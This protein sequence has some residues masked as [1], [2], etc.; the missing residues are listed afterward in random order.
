ML[1]KSLLSNRWSS[2]RAQFGW[3]RD[4]CQNMLLFC[5]LGFF[6]R[7]FT[8]SLSICT[9]ATFYIHTLEFAQFYFIPYSYSIIFKMMTIIAIWKVFSSFFF[10]LSLYLLFVHFVC[11]FECLFSEE[12]MSLFFFL[13][14]IKRIDTNVCVWVLFLSIAKIRNKSKN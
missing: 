6:H 8:C 1:H 12:H 9:P 11:F 14:W 13:F 4:G 7:S 10:A 3:T 5:S 2:D